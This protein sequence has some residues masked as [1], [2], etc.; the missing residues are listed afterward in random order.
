MPG[1]NV[2]SYR[3]GGSP[4]ISATRFTPAVFIIAGQFAVDG[5]VG[6]KIPWYA[7]S[8]IDLSRAEAPAAR[9]RQTSRADPIP[10]LAM[11]GT[12]GP[13]SDLHRTNKFDSTLEKWG[14]T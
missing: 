4:S 7:K 3:S 2:F 9:T 10:P 1:L 11:I 12:C 8:G 5:T 14:A 13:S 6:K